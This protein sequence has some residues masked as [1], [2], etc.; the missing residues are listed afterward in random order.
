MNFRLFRAPYQKVCPPVQSRFRISGRGRDKARSQA[1]PIFRTIKKRQS[2]LTKLLKTFRMTKI[3]LW[4]MVIIET[5]RQELN[6]LR[7]ASHQVTTET[8]R[9][10]RCCDGLIRQDPTRRNMKKAAVSAR[11]ST[12]KTK[13][14]PWLSQA[15]PPAT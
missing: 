2:T 13:I 1:S 5:W 9:H 12:L 15:S 14:L 10:N 7:D 8:L 3:S 6:H 4:P 11:S